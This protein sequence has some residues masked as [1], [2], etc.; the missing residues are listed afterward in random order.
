MIKIKA[1]IFD[2]DGVLVDSEPIHTAVENKLFKFLKLDISDQEYASYQGT[3]TG[4]MWMS[5]KK[6]HNLKTPLE[7]LVKMT[8]YLTFMYFDTLEGIHGSEDFTITT[9]EILLW[10]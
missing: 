2:M 10:H 4:A 1:V 6:K 3:S 5:V 8:E 7:E 9:Q